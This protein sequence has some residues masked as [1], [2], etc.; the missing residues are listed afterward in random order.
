M[1]ADEFSSGPL[2]VATL[3]ILA[4]RAG[5][6]PLVDGWTFEPDP[7]SPRHLEL[8][9]SEDQY[10]ESVTT[11]RLDVRWFE[12]GDYTFHYLEFRGEDV[13]QC[14]WDRHPKPGT[15]RAHFH[16]PP[17]AASSTV[18]PGLNTTHHLDVLFSVLDWLTERVEE[19]HE[20]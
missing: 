19:L 4:A 20:K 11:V 13:W 14:R 15:P 17:D 16:P 9:C 5:T 10:P 2:D 1:S 6:H 18:S 3:E 8:T 12:T 7:M